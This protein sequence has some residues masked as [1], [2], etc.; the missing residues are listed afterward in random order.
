M[1]HKPVLLK[2]AVELLNIQPGGTYVDATFGSGG[3]SREIL[4]YLESGRLIAFDQDEDARQ[5]TFSDSQFLFIPQNFRYI[6]NFLKAHDILKV[7]G[8]MADLG[9][10]SWQIDQ[11]DRGFST[12]SEGKLDM[13]MDRQ[14]DLTAKSLLNEYS[15]KQLANLLYEFGEISNGRQLAR[16]IIK[17]RE[18]K[19][20][21][22]T[23]DLKNLATRL[24]PK[25][26]E[27]Q[28]LAKV[29]QAIR[30]DVNDELGSLKE[31]LKQS[32]KLL[33]TGKRIVIISYHSLED[34]LVKN[35]FNT[36]NFQ[37]ELE[38]DFYGNPISP[39]KQITRK[40]IMPAEEEIKENPRSR[41]AKLRAAERI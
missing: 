38:K 16:M 6:K 2:K 30:I 27:N 13:R 35:F 3:H 8:I 31:L 40:A 36:G 23:L 34:R 5:N 24:A 12:R 29:F 10:S 32:V 11:A 37:G 19:K 33:D 21:E 26:K 15:E 14:Q 4:S 9:I 39:L 28:Y 7:D 20:L 22:T 41:S 1:Y 18:E 17:H 25:G